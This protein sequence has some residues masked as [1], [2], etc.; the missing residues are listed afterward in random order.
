[1]EKLAEAA[2]VTPRTLQSRCHE[3]RDVLG[4]LLDPNYIYHNTTDNQKKLKAKYNE[5]EDDT[6]KR[7]D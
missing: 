4:R 2:G 3:L 5:D 1:M 6:R 7:V